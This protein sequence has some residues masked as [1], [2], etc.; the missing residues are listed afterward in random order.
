MTDRQRSAVYAA[1]EQW[2]AAVDRGG[3]MDF[4]GSRIVLPCQRRFASLDEVRAYVDAVCA[5][6]GLDAPAVRH[7]R[8]GA[9]AHYEIVDG[10]GHIAIPEGE[11]WAMREAVVLHELAHHAS[12]TMDHGAA[13]TAAMVGLVEAELGPEA[14]LVLRT[15]YLASGVGVDVVD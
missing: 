10:A 8:G 13:F 14:A 5:R 3:P 9:R 2:A 12:A 6:H 11:P 7:R 15:G 1:E 4:L